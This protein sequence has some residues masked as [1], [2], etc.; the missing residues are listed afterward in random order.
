MEM[1]LVLPLVL[2]VLYAFL[3][4]GYYL[5]ARLCLEHAVVRAMEEVALGTASLD[6]L[7]G[8]IASASPLAPVS[9]SDMEIELH[10]RG[11][12][13]YGVL[14]VRVR[15]K[16]DSILSRYLGRPLFSDLEVVCSM[17]CSSGEQAV[18]RHG[19]GGGG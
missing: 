1:A 9:S 18:P 10:G 4:V 14:H 3:D 12:G 7:P 5:T 15:A 2:M 16:V 19:H 11:A 17:P 8:R 6:A 13:G